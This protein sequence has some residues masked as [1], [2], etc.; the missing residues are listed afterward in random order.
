MVCMALLTKH[1]LPLC[2]NARK[3]AWLSEFQ[4][5]CEVAA[6]VLLGAPL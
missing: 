3:L 2:H 6:S 1:T 5:D 4:V